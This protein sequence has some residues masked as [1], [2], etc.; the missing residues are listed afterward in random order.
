MDYPAAGGRPSGGN[1]G[2]YAKG[3]NKCREYLYRLS[4]NPEP[5]QKLSRAQ[6]LDYAERVEKSSVV[7]V[8]RGP[9]CSIAA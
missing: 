7:K 1:A 9:W 2:V 8:S 5:G 4:V 3:L 6:Y